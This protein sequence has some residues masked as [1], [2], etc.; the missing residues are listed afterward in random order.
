MNKTSPQLPREFTLTND[1]SSYAEEFLIS[2]LPITNMKST[3]SVVRDE[4]FYRI[5]IN[6]SIFDN[7]TLHACN[8]RKASFI[9][10]VFQTCDLSNTEFQNAYFERCRFISCK[11]LGVNMS[12]TVIKKTVF[13]ESNLQYSYF[14]RSRM[15]DVVFEEIDFTEASM[16][17]ATLKKF[18]PNKSK[19][20]KNNFHRTLLATVDFTNSELAAPIV[21]SPPVE[22]KGAT[23]D[24]F[25]AANLIGLWGIIV[26]L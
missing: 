13:E 3:G 19:F 20:L 8:F 14:D 4:G 2:E 22:L 12:D 26:K 6:K 7:C 1:F 25:Q 17:E 15:T 5:E 9:D 23:I 10:V 16:A 18:Q 21:S 24:M 11:C